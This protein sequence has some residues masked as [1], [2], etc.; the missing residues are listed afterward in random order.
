MRIIAHK[1]LQA[2]WVKRGR[3]DSR[4]P[5]EA[6]YAEAAKAQWTGPADIKA[7]YATASFVGERV[8][9]NIGGNKY[10]LV[11]FVHYGFKT[12]YIRFVGT[13][14]E[15]DAIDVETI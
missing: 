2:H 11:V 4:G 6:W 15:Y 12:I 13:H 9:F 1:S 8:V 7:R 3:E 5:L 14:A 10:R